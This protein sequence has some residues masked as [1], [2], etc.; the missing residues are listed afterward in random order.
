MGQK[1]ELDWTDFPSLVRSIAERDHE[2]VVV[3]IAAELDVSTALLNQWVHGLVK[4]PSTKNLFKLSQRY[5]VPF[6]DLIALVARRQEVIAQGKAPRRQG[7]RIAGSL[8]LALTMGGRIVDP[9]DAEVEAAA[10]AAV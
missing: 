1:R 10:G 8:L 2:G 7:R 4:S 3:R 6:M 9:V 5:G